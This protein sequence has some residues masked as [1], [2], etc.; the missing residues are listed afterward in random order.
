MVED[1]HITVFDGAQVSLI[2]QA[3]ATSSRAALRPDGFGD[4]WLVKSQTVFIQAKYTLDA[5]LPEKN[6]FTKAVAVGGPFLR[7]NVLV[8]G[9]LDDLITWNGRPIL[10]SMPSEFAVHGLIVAKNH[11]NASLVQDTAR[12]SPGLEI[13]LPSNVKLLVNRFRKHVNVAIKMKRSFELQ[14]GLCGNFN[15]FPGDDLPELVQKRKT[16]NV[17]P[18]DSLFD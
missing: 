13:E 9:S 7:N 8:V 3:R 6:V 11:A 15:A 10:D 18:Y 12:R 14:D 1:P 17:E 16:Q 5:S 2:N 4:K